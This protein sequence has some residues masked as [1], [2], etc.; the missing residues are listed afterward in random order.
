MEQIQDE[1]L[2]KE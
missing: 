2:M 1:L